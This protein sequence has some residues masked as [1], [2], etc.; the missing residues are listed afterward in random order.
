MR[1]RRRSCEL[2]VPPI[3]H[4]VAASGSTAR[5]GT[6]RARI[7]NAPDEQAHFQFNTRFHA[8]FQELEHTPSTPLAAIERVAQPAGTVSMNE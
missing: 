2:L 5:P 6:K 7:K 8:S 1:A 3:P 4:A